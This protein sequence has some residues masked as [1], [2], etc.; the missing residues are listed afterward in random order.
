MIRPLPEGGAGN[1]DHGG[2]MFSKTPPASPNALH[3]RTLGGPTSGLVAVP[4]SEGGPGLPMVSASEVSLDPD[5]GPGPPMTPLPEEEPE[6][7]MTDPSAEMLTPAFP[8]TAEWAAHPAAS[9]TNRPLVLCIRPSLSVAPA[10]AVNGV[11]PVSFDEVDLLLYRRAEQSQASRRSTTVTVLRETMHVA[12]AP[13]VGRWEGPPRHVWVRR[14][15]R[16]V[17]SS[18]PE[19]RNLVHPRGVRRRNGDGGGRGLDRAFLR[20]RRAALQRKARCFHEVPRGER[21]E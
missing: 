6:L 3:G 13:L 15:G 10:T 11:R 1:F 14:C 16:R 9:N 19:F 7:P 12:Q 17:E 2:V 18:S 5:P 8:S 4:P 21:A 20:P